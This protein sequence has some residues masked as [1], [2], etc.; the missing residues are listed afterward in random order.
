MKVVY[1]AVLVLLLVASTVLS[2]QE[3][4]EHTTG[5]FSG[6]KV[7]GGTAPHS[8][9]E[10]QHILTLSGDFVP[11]E[12]PDPHWQVV[13][14]KGNV[15]QL[16]KLTIKDGKY[17][18]MIVVPSYVPDIARVQIWCAFAE[19]LLGEATFSKTIALR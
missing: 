13:D 3:K 6:V 5:M 7:N 11:P 12:A 16:Q 17:N 19:T 1:G 18:S 15:Y 10:G 8:V 4:M 9:R 2:A 14:S